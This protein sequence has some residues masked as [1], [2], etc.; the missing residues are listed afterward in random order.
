MK[1]VFFIFEE[2]REAAGR[3]KKG[4]SVSFSSALRGKSAARGKKK[5]R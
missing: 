5:L 2:K 3:G 1:V 4:K